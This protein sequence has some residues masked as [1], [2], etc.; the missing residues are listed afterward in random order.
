[1]IERNSQTIVIPST[2]T[3]FC[4]LPSKGWVNL[5]YIRTVR[6]FYKIHFVRL[7]LFSCQVIWSNGDREKFTGADAQ[8]IAQA[9]S[10]TIFTATGT[11]SRMNI[12]DLS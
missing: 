8:A 4:K 11:R 7:P 5:T 9:L 10:K 2:W 3:P 1:M 6:F 12:K